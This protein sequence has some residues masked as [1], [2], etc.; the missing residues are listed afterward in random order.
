MSKKTRKTTKQTARKPA[1]RKAVA[2]ATKRPAAAADSATVARIAL[3]LESI[4]ASLGKSAAGPSGADSLKKAD[5]FVWH[6]PGSVHAPSS[7]DGCELLV[8]LPKA[9]EI[10]RP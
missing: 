9:I 3:A 10:V 2:A 1:G 7:A 5:A 8:V 6:P 4:A